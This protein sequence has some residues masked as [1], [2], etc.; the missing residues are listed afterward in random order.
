[1]LMPMA[2]EIMT[3]NTLFSASFWTNAA[4]LFVE[5]TIQQGCSR[6]AHL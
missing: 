3:A 4:I 5:H 2:D 1:M 6:K